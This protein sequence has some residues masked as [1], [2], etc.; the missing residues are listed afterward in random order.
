MQ[1]T[2]QDFTSSLKNVDKGNLLQ[3]LVNTA[4]RTLGG[5]KRN[6]QVSAIMI[7]SPLATTT[8]LT[9]PG[10]AYF[11]LIRRTLLDLYCQNSRH[12]H[13]DH[14]ERSNEIY[15]Q[16][17]A[18][19]TLLILLQG[20]TA[21]GFRWV[22]NERR[23][24]WFPSKEGSPLLPP[25]MIYQCPSFNPAKKWARTH[26]EGAQADD[27]PGPGQHEGEPR[28]DEPLLPGPEPVAGP[29]GDPA[30]APDGPAAPNPRRGPCEAGY[31]DLH[32]YQC[33]AW[34]NVCA[35]P[36]HGCVPSFYGGDHQDQG[37]F[38]FII[39]APARPFR[40]QWDTRFKM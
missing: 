23:T 18:K 33:P 11:L 35:D 40:G 37:Q 9:I 3:P 19:T 28:E 5:G 22:A 34:S 30:V 21:R 2:I 4:C 31:A 39:Q 17:G 8:Y 7:K 12:Q 10:L 25:A 27:I 29:D 6:I 20:I 32:T 38:P 16:H 1:F 13:D 36:T 15:F 14:R 26:M 24:T